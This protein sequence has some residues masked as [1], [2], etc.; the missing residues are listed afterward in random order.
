[1]HDPRMMLHMHMTLDLKK[2]SPPSFGDTGMLG[3]A[4][5]W[6]DLAGGNGG[7]LVLPSV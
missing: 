1:M 6:E 2:G 3:V 4:A 5:R 7:P